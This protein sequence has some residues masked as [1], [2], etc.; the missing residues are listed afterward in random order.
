VL[1][2]VLFRQ[3]CPVPARLVAK[4]VAHTGRRPGSG[5]VWKRLDRSG[6]VPSVV[7]VESPPLE[8]RKASSACCSGAQKAN[9]V[10]QAAEKARRRYGRIRAA[11]V[12]ELRAGRTAAR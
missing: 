11:V 6:Y 1:P 4:K 9:A 5:I 2:H 8:W 10:H 7:F 12:A 3:T